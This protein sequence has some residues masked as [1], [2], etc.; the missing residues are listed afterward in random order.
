MPPALCL[1]HTNCQ[2]DA[3][4]PLLENTPAFA[5]LFRIRQYV[6]Y[7]REEIGRV[8]LRQCALFLYQW[9][10][11]KWGALSTEQLLPRLPPAC[12]TL[13][14]PNLFFKG[15]WPTWTREAPIDFG[16][17]LLESLLAQGLTPTEALALYLRG[18]PPLLGDRAALEAAAEA[19][20]A[21]EEAKEAAASIRCAPL[22]RE[23]WREEQLFVTINHPGRELMCHV[24]DSL[25]RLLGLGG[26]PPSVR[27]AYVSP[28]EDFWL[29]VHPAVGERLGLPFARRDR[30][31]PIYGQALTHREYTACY[32]A[33]RSEKAADFL[34]FLR[35]LSPQGLAALR[36]GRLPGAWSVPM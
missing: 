18:A 31:Y 1:L 15:Y 20:L 26:L 2:G 9:L 6:N 22:I 5:R 35:H 28:L 12:R 14:V 7:T 24:A 11:P 10:A 19:S 36:A 29:P 25:L 4:R 3:L 27:R 23:R 34:A 8:D 30:R 33:C 21:R 32:L 17:S 13:T 16:D